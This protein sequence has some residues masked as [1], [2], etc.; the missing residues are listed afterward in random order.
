LDT[1]KPA[2]QL[3]LIA[4][5]D[6]L[7]IEI[8]NKYRRRARAA[9]LDPDDVEQAAR[10]GLIT[11]AARY[12]PARGEFAAYARKYVVG[13]ICR[14]F[15]AE[16]DE[17]DAVDPDIIA[18]RE[19]QLATERRRRD[20]RD[21]DVREALA[22]LPADQADA[23]A[24]LHGLHDGRRWSRRE[25]AH[26]SGLSPNTIRATIDAATAALLAELGDEIA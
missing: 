1:L 7:A 9:G 19:D 12:R 5:H 22:R 16:A 17:P 13:E 23:M 2:D 20:D 14:I 4:E 25:I 18:G 6:H 10:L 26:K 21:D 11:A 3:A 8:A 15:S 24:R